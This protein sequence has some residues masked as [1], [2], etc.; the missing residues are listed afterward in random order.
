[1]FKGGLLLATIASLYGLS[2]QQSV[3]NCKTPGKMADST[4]IC[5]DCNDG[6]FLNSSYSYTHCWGC[7]TRCSKCTIQAATNALICTN[8]TDG[9]RFNPLNLS[10]V[11]CPSNCK[12]CSETTCLQCMDGYTLNPDLVCESKSNF[13]QYA[14]IVAVVAGVAFVIWW[15]YKTYLKGTPED[16]MNQANEMGGNYTKDKDKEQKKMEAP[17]KGGRR[18]NPDN[19]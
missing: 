4:D 2:Q 16:P 3:P 5:L 7:P 13:M 9:F 18:A 10:C 6:Y 14:F 15:V 12:A 17:L 8:C 11:A 1:M 19:N